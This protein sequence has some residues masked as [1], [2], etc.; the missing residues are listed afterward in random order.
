MVSRFAPFTLEMRQSSLYAVDGAQKVDFVN[1][2][3]FFRGRVFYR[4]INRNR[5]TLHPGIEPAEFVN[6]FLSNGLDLL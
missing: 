1:A 4:R 5:S 3:E 2:A 6:G